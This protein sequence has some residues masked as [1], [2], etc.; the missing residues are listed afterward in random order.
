M[1]YWISMCYCNPKRK[2]N[3]V[4]AQL[5]FD[6]C[7]NANAITTRCSVD[8]KKLKPLCTMV[9]VDCFRLGE[10]RLVS[11]IAMSC[12]SNLISNSSFLIR[13]SGFPDYAQGYESFLTF[14][15]L[16][17]IRNY[18]DFP[19]KKSILPKKEINMAASI[20]SIHFKSNYN[21][22]ECEQVECSP[23]SMVYYV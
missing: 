9:V 7:N 5:L 21:Q 4:I 12:W 6:V 20:L 2:Q 8:S 15:L 10:C 1:V 23:F 16:L 14:V 13:I 22:S 19:R 11:L 3:R 17:Q 18:T